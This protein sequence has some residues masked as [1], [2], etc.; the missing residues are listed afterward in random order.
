VSAKTRGEHGV[1]V[2]A[3]GDDEEL[4]ELGSS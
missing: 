4:D 2:L 3:Q 1:A